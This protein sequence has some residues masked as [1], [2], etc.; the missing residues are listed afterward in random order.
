MNKYWVNPH[1]YPK[2]NNDQEIYQEEHIHKPLEG[3]KHLNGH[4]DR[5]SAYRYAKRYFE[6]VDSCA[7]YIPGTLTASATWTCF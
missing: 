1:T 5:G 6:D 3:R 7:V 2:P 4:T